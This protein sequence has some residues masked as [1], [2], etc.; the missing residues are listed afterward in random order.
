MAKKYVITRLNPTVNNPPILGVY[1]S[2]E[3]A[4]N[5]LNEYLDDNYFSDTLLNARSFQDAEMTSLWSGRSHNANPL[6]I[7]EVVTT[8]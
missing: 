8:D 5:A 4:I 7:H 1:A 2:K 3:A 6:V